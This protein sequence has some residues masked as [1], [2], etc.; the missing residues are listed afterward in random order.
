MPIVSA[1]K[2]VDYAAPPG[3]RALEQLA[4][5]EATRWFEHA[6]ALHES[7]AAELTGAD[8]D[9]LLCD[10]LVG[11]GIAAQQ[12]GDP[13]FRATLLRASELAGADGRHRAPGA[14]RAGQHARLRVSET[15]SVDTERVS[16]SRQHWRRSARRQRRSRARL[17]ATLSAELTFAGDW[18][19]RKALSD[20][21]LELAARLG[22]P[23]TLSEVLSHRFITIWTPETLAQRIED[24]DRGLAIAQE[25]GDPLAQFRATHWRAAAAV[26]AGELDLAADLVAPSPRSPSGCTDLPRA[27]WPPT[28]ARRR[29]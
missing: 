12:S 24:T 20:E 3:E 27:G 26:E 1:A 6:L 23:E 13:E 14:R 18:D 9:T 22:D 16:C 4:P 17:L 10:L 19:R 7:A 21:S 29:R 2:A 25:V 15:G 11:S 28:T 8:D 5:Q